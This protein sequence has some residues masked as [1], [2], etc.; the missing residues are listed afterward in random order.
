MLMASHL[1]REIEDLVDDLV[2]ISEGRIVESGSMSDFL[3]RFRQE[4]V[5]VH[6]DEVHQLV[7]AVQQAGGQV[8]DQV[9]A[10]RVTFVGLTA[11]EISRI[12]RER[13]LLIDEISTQRQLE[14]AFEAATWRLSEAEGGARR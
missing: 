8:R 9:R 12:A 13:D 2:V 1:L 11:K 3:E 5:V 7:S 14:G 4:T 6:C 10:D